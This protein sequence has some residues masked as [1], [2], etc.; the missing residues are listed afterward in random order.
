MNRYICMGVVL[1]GVLHGQLHTWE[2]QRAWMY[3]HIAPYKRVTLGISLI[4]TGVGLFH[5]G[6]LGM[7]MSKGARPLRQESDEVRYVESDQNAAI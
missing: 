5:L 7:L 4:S 6:R 2:D 1:F 3:A